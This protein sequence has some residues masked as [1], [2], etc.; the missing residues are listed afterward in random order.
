[1]IVCVPFPTLISH[2]I[3]IRFAVDSPDL[4]RQ[5]PRKGESAFVTKRHS[6][7]FLVDFR[8]AALL[9]GSANPTDRLQEGFEK[10]S[11]YNWRAEKDQPTT[12][13]V[14][15]R[16]GRVPENQR[17]QVPRMFCKRRQWRARGVWAC[18]ESSPDDIEKQE[19]ER[20]HGF[21]IRFIHSLEENYFVHLGGADVDIQTL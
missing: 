14:R 19:E 8:G 9:P 21:V 15:G 10:R 11:S 20:L 18:N 4:A 5:R 16:I 12:R 7:T 17:L 1:M 3:S 13:D 6:T 2:V